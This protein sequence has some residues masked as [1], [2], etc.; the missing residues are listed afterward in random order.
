MFPNQK[1][2]PLFLIRIFLGGVFF[3]SGFSKLIDPVENFSAVITSYQVLPAGWV[4]PVAFFLP[5]L[6]LIFGTFLV[7]GFLTRAS[8]AF[9]AA[10]SGTFIVLL[11]RSMILKLPITEC[12]CFG[13]GIVLAPWQ[14]LVLD[15]GL[16]LMALILIL[17]HPR[18]EN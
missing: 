13:A 5:W 12:G 4:W 11:S 3:Y 17:F 10:L 6:E 2:V 7:L 18:H 16:F 1:A 8:A 15:T 14:A 9:L